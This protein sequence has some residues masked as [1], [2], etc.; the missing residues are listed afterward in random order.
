MYKIILTKSKVKS[1]NSSNNKG[2]RK[3]K[4]KELLLKYYINT[5]I[6]FVIVSV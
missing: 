1:I 3:E 2:R 5:T 6:T 4:R